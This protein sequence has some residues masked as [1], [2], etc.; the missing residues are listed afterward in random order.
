MERTFGVHQVVKPRANP[1]SLR[2]I[3]SH[4]PLCISNFSRV[5]HQP[6]GSIIYALGWMVRGF[7][8]LV[9]A[10]P[11]C[12]PSKWFLFCGCKDLI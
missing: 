8:F 6:P 9:T 4:L 10:A 5:G 3:V 7:F 1:L 12:C 2:C 11:P